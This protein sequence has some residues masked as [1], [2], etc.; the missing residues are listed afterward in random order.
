MMMAQ[1]KTKIKRRARRSMRVVADR[2]VCCENPKAMDGSVSTYIQASGSPH[3]Y[4]V[5]LRP[6]CRTGYAQLLLLERIIRACLHYR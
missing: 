4:V 6:L 3:W 2:I 5:K 1:V